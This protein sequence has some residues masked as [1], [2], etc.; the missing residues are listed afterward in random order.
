MSEKWEQIDYFV[1]LLIESDASLDLSDAEDERV[2][3]YHRYRRN[4]DSMRKAIVFENELSLNETEKA[5]IGRLIADGC[6]SGRTDCEESCI[7]WE[8]RWNKWTD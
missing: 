5:E 8:L 1:S 2:Q 3:E 6:T 4:M 7:A